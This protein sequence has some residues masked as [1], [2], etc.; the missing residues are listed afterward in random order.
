M[1]CTMVSGLVLIL[2]DF[3]TY[4]IYIL[5]IVYTLCYVISGTFQRKLSRFK[6]H[7]V[8]FIDMQKISRIIRNIFL[9]KLVYAYMIMRERI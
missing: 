1:L 9:T 4:C 7:Y 5:Y 8:Y 2:M 6:D 3:G